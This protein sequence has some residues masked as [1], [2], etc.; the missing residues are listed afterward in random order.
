VN[1]NHCVNV[2][3]SANMLTKP[4]WNIGVAALC[5]LQGLGEASLIM[6]FYSLL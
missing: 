4:E 1:F 6:Q 3:Y 5:S 2:D